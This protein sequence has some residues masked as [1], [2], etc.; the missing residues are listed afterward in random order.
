M[1][2]KIKT[3]SRDDYLRALALYTMASRLQ[4]DVDRF[5]AEMN[6]VLGLHVEDG[7]LG[8]RMSDGIYSRPA[9]NFDILLG[10]CD[11]EV[12]AEVIPPPASHGES[13]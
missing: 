4:A 13:E 6:K 2:D 9:E 8:S 3:I 12:A 10:Y 5:D 1:A 7:H 11:I